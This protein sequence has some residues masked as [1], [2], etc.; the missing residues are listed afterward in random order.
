MKTGLYISLL[1][2]LLLAN[3]SCSNKTEEKK[4]LAV[5]KVDTVQSASQ[6]YTLQFPGKIKAAQDVSLAFRVSGT[7]A[8]IYAQEGARVSKGQLLAELDPTDYKVQLSATQAE[9]SAIKNEAERVMALYKDGATT[10]D[11][12]DKARYGLEQITAKLDHHKQQLSYT[13]LY[14]PFSGKIQRHLFHAYETVAAGMPVL[15]MIDE[16][17]PEVEINL[18]AAD[19]VRRHLFSSYSCTLHLYP[20]TRYD[21]QLVSISPKA[22]SNQL[23]TMRL[24]LL[25]SKDQMPVPGM[26]TMVTIDLSDVDNG[27]M[28][29]PS[30]ALVNRG[31]KSIVYLFTPSDSKVKAVYVKPLEL[32]TDGTTIISAK[33]LKPGDTVVTAGSHHIADGQ[34]VKLL[35]PASP[36]NIGGLL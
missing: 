18:P 15:S 21:L 27:F 31:G 22:N 20:G 19:Y 23:Y 9:Y 10:P 36:T 24:K 16:T 35:P 2:T 6:L 7:I 25:A 17:A 12:Y 32:K 1:A 29:I 26:N 5:V 14:A 3:T 33:G 11:N 34:Q 28:T 13:K 8:H 4:S 30:S